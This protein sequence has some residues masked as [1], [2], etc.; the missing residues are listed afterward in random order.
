MQAGLIEA[1]LFANGSIGAAPTSGQAAL[2]FEAILIG[3]L[4]KAAREAGAAEEEDSLAGSDTYRE[5]A[6]KHLARALVEN[7]SFGFARML[8]RSLSASRDSHRIA[9][10]QAFVAPATPPSQVGSAASLRTALGEERQNSA[11]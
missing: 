3:Q 11:V 10:S 1:A 9:Q 5:F 4:L 6:E 2:E 8:L 7:G